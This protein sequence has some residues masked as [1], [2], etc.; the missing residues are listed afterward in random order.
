MMNIIVHRSEPV[1]ESVTLPAR[2]HRQV[3]PPRVTYPQHRTFL[4]GSARSCPVAS[5][6]IASLETGAT[7]SRS[8]W[9]IP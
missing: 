9:V 5:L 6:S 8:I 2:G 4:L 3:A 1:R 7:T